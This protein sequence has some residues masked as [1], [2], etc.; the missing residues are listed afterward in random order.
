MLEP[1]DPRDRDDALDVIHDEALREL[2]DA[3]RD[4]E[5]GGELVAPPPL[6][7]LYRPPHGGRPTPRADA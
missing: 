5:R 3:A 7:R 2:N 1:F 4:L 6:G